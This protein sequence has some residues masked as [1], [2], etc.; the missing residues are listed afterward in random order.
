MILEMVLFDRPEGCS[1]ADLLED[2][3]SVADHWRANP[4]LLRKHFVKNDAGKVA[5]VYIWPDRAAAERAH[6]AA[7]VARFRE[8]TGVEPEISYFDLFMLI[9][10]EAGTVTEYP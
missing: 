3:R 8:R 1:D 2:A 10:N 5:G 9:D 6:D 4:D 7:W